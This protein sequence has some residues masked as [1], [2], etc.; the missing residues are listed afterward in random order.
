M[1]QLRTILLLL[2]LFEGSTA[3]GQELAS[4]N[5]PQSPQFPLS[6]WKTNPFA[7]LWGS[8]PFTGEYRFNNELVCGQLASFE[9][10]VSYLGRSPFIRIFEEELSNPGSGE[11]IRIKVS[12][13]RFQTAFRRYF[14]NSRTKF[15]MNDLAP[16]GYYMGIHFSYSTAV[17]TNKFYRAYDM[18]IQG[19]HANMSVMFGRQMVFSE[20]FT[21]DWFSTLGWKN[22]DWFLND[23]QYNQ[24]QSLLGDVPDFYRG[25]IRFAMGFNFGFDL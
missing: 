17:F 8:V 19:T 7:T 18:Y 24:K 10:G 16:Q 21:I 22:N 12:G 23:T 1:K 25:H 4:G 11:P 5:S 3:S 9:F 13:F 14:G 20:R 6:I 2:I 15:T